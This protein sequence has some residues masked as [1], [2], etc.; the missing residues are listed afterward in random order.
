MRLLTLTKKHRLII[1]SLLSQNF[2]EER[3][4]FDL[5]IS[6][7]TLSNYCTHIQNHFGNT[8]TLSKKR[9]VLSLQVNDASQFKVILDTL[10]DELNTLDESLRNRN[11]K[12]FNYLLQHEISNIDDISKYLFLSK[13]SVT[14][15]IHSLKLIFKD[16]NI[17]I[18]GITNVGLIIDASE[19]QI[20]KIII[21][22]F[23]ELVNTIKLNEI[24]ESFTKEIALKYQLESQ[25]ISN[26]IIAIKVTEIRL[27]DGYLMNDISDI[28]TEIYNS[29]YYK[30][31][32]K[33]MTYWESK[34]KLNIKENEILLIV[35]QL[36]GRRVTILD[37]FKKQE[38]SEIID[39]I[40]KDTA[41][42][43]NYFYK[44][45]IDTT[46]FSN[47]IRAHLMQ[48]VNRIVFNITIKDKLVSGIQKKSPLS[49]E[50]SKILADHIENKLN[51]IVPIHEL[52][53]IALYFSA[54]IEEVER[55]LKTINSIAII[56]DQGLSTTKLLSSHLR[57]ILGSHVNID[58]YH[59]NLLTPDLAKQYELI[60]STIQVTQMFNKIVYIED[61]LNQSLLQS[62]IEQ[63]LIYKD[64]NNRKFYNH[65]TLVDCLYPEDFSLIE[66]SQKFKTLIKNMCLELINSERVEPS[67]LKK[68]LKKESERSTINGAIAF[69]HTGY[70]GKD[71]QIKIT[72]IKNGMNKSDDLKLIILM[73]IP[74]INIIEPILIR[75]Y[76]EV[77]AI[78]T[79]S[80]LI[81]KLDSV[82]SYSE[83]IE[84]LNQEMRK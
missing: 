6:L 61:V 57:N 58:I 44:I 83:F 75:L 49:Y 35:L 68:I 17:Q 43:I 78:N 80:Y 84:L 48:M 79:N 28:S 76:E 7:R 1:E 33:L 5:N 14:N 22:K 82:K 54:Y 62:K 11:R 52:H 41:K 50:L 24:L 36:I 47:D 38:H 31:C 30:D 15:A 25:T 53:F 13:S 64:V 27:K 3:L 69:P 46:L 42:D 20:R 4:A 70:D 34:F 37:Q 66:D 73:G 51:I 55:Q 45:N 74:N 21:E 39:R 60:I 19:Y 9:G 63:F 16:Y 29:E 2:Q 67:F 71:I 40:I 8:I 10:D 12:I 23:P 65:S 32:K 81:N 72:L 18:H 59:I 77:L 56:T 26:I